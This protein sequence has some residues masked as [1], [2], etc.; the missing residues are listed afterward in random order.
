MLIVEDKLLYE[1]RWTWFTEGK[2]QARFDKPERAKIYVSTSQLILDI[3]LTH[4]AR[5]QSSQFQKSNT[6]TSKHRLR[7]VRRPF[8]VCSVFPRGNSEIT[9]SHLQMVTTFSISSI[10]SAFRKCG[11]IVCK[12]DHQVCEL[13]NQMLTRSK[14]QL[15]DN[16]KA[17]S[18]DSHAVM[19]MQ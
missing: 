12:N 9:Q 1:T 2:T 7:K 11:E 17:L 4:Q 16:L 13:G 5:S 10:A 6:D 3:R 19:W 18:C 14:T 15:A 8:F